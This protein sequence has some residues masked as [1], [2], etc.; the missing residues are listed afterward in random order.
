MVNLIKKNNI[1]VIYIIGHLESNLIY[2]YIDPYCFE[3]TTLS[4]QLRSYKLKDCIEI[5]N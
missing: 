2:D 1:S 4:K 5:D 3:E